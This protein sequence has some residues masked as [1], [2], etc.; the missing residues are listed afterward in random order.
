[1]ARCTPASSAPGSV[2][3]RWRWAPV[4][5]TSASWRARSSSNGTSRPTETP[6]REL[7]ALGHE[8]LDPAVDQVLLE[9]EVG[10]AVAQQPARRGRR[11]RTR[12]PRGPRARVAELRRGRPAP[13]RRCRRNGPCAAPAGC[14]VIQPSSQARSTIAHSIS[15]IVTASSLIVRTQASSQGAGQSLPVSSGKLLVECSCSLASC[16]L[17][18]CTRSFQS[19]MRLPSGQPRVAE[20][21]AA[22]HAAARLLAHLA[23]G[24]VQ[25]HV[26]VV[27]Q[28]LERRAQRAEAPLHLE[29]SARI[30]HGRLRARGRARPRCAAGRAA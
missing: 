4:A 17:P 21:H 24:R 14:G 15:L 11:A 25:V 27:A 30:S 19:G 5:S 3:A 20:R 16:Q 26:A 13:S 18:R 12:S 29:E 10:D 9:L 2:S 22:R 28:A 23:L 1:M 8:L 6:Q 7:D